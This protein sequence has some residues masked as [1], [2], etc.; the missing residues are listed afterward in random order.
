MSGQVL[1]YETYIY[2]THMRCQI[3]D[4]QLT[5][6]TASTSDAIVFIQL[7]SMRME[8]RIAMQLQLT[9]QFPSRV[10]LLAF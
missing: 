2:Y 4:N 5:W 3:G 6:S 10:T 8:H 1:L 9:F 7:D